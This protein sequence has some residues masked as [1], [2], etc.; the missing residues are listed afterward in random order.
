MVWAASYLLKEAMWKWAGP[1]V[2]GSPVGG[3]KPPMPGV[4]AGT[5][6]APSAGGGIGGVGGMAKNLMNSPLTM[7]GAAQTLWNN[8]KQ[9][10]PLG[11]PVTAT[12]PR[13]QMRT[14]LSQNEIAT[15]P[16]SAVGMGNVLAKTM[17]PEGSHIQNVQQP[18]IK[19]TLPPMQ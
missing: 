8:Q 15:A 2:P 13:N 4:G 16:V 12:T 9:Q 1:P 6:P 7:N 11:Q 18:N 3:T 17:M 14:N 10:K 5:P 19:T